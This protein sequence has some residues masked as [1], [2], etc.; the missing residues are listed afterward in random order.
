MKINPLYKLL[1]SSYG[2]S[3]FSE[4]IILPIYAVFVQNIG[5]DILDASGAMATFLITQWVFTVI[6]HRIPWTAKHRIPV[7]IVGWIIWLLGIS[8][9]LTI[10]S[11][12]ML[13]VTQVLT[14]LGNAIADPIFDAELAEHTDKTNKIYER[15]LF[16]GMQD[17]IAGIAAIVWGMLVAYYGFK[18]L[19]IM[20]IITATLS[21]IL[22]LYYIQKIRRH[23]SLHVK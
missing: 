11:V 7:M 14:A 23:T 21:L 13:F 22:I 8:L 19:I 5:G 17:I 18:S 20:M 16:E 9:Y 2:L 4:W 6:V 12:E 15:W 10:S 1:I 3:L